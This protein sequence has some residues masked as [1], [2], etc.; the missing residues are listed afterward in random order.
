M[1]APLR[2]ATQKGSRQIVKWLAEGLTRKEIA[3]RL[4]TTVGSLWKFYGVELRNAEKS[5]KH[6]GKTV[7]PYGYALSDTRFVHGVEPPA[8]CPFPPEM[9]ATIV[10]QIV[11]FD[12]NGMPCNGRG[13]PL[14][15]KKD[16]R[17][18]HARRGF[19]GTA[20][21][22]ITTVSGVVRSTLQADW[23]CTNPS[24]EKS[25]MSGRSLIPAAIKRCLNDELAKKAVALFK[26]FR[27]ADVPGQPTMEEAA[28]EWFLELVEVIIGCYD[29]V[30]KRRMLKEIFLLVPKKNMKTTGGALIML[31][32]LIYNE[33]PNGEAIMTA[34]VHDV[35]EIAFKA[36]SGAIELD[37]DLKRIFD[38]QPHLKTIIDLRTNATL[39]VMTFDPAVLTG[40]KLF[41]A[42]IDEL[43]VIARNPKADSA[44]RQIRGG[45]MPFN[46]AILI[47]ITTQSE[48]APSGVF[49]SELIAARAIRDGVRK[50]ARVLPILYEF[51]EDLQKGKDP[52]LN[53]RDPALWGLVTPNMGRSI[54]LDTL[55]TSM[56][57]A[58]SKSEA[59]VR[60]WAS[61]H[62]NIEI[63]LAL[64]S[65]AWSGAEV[66]TRGPSDAALDL[67]ALLA[68]CEVVEVGVDGGGLNDLLALAVAG[69]EKETGLWLVWAKAWAHPIVLER[70]KPTQV[71][72]LDLQKAGE[73]VFVEQPGDDMEELVD[74][75]TR[76]ERAGLLDKIGLDPYGVGGI[77]DALL[78]ADIPKESIV[79]ISQGW[80]LGGAIKTLER[81]IAEGKLVHADQ[82]L[83][84]WCVSNAR[85]EMRSNAVLI[86][87]AASGAAKIDALMA[88]LNAIHLLS[89][90]PA[91]KAVKYQI[92]VIGASEA[93][94][95]GVR[96]AAP[97]VQRY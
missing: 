75:V 51:P 74:I 10:H 69:R 14:F 27:L 88:L 36:I 68:R 12:F 41:A 26:T 85:I 62:L 43:H 42:L 9:L 30:T 76:C 22:A 65:N 20:R 79:G 97:R 31:L 13:Q 4:D 2:K 54:S 7:T 38:V 17:L 23:D 47:F 80:R 32:L 92:R 1:S 95:Q 18:A 84:N 21:E 91:S 59:E 73:L 11:K 33:R 66:W 29:P 48:E 55:V 56:R 5:V 71:Q 44:L 77:V 83:L 28:G 50:D 19:H 46:E 89:T 90:N 58:E 78:T 70:N 40:Q 52:K 60:S 87:K 94:S 53:W 93:P 67:D 49:A 39:S 86:T 24:W 57:D 3:A 63:G 72:L 16:L 81:A 64:R 15:G 82:P 61:Q 6:S 96:H 8:N 37:A 45:M 34:P 35:A 25:L